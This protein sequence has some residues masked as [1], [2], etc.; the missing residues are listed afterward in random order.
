MSYRTPSATTWSRRRFLPTLAT[1]LAISVT[2]LMSREASAAEQIQPLNR[3]PRMVHEYFVKQVRQSQQGNRLAN[4]SVKTKGDAQ[5]YIDEVR[6]KIRECFGPDPQRTPLNAHVTGVIE[7]EAYRIEKLIF[8]SRPNF[9]VTANVYVPNGIDR[10]VPGVVGTC[11]HTP[12]GKAAESYQA[13]AQ[14]LAKQGY[15][16]I[17]YDPIGQGERSQYVNDQL[18]SQI[19]LGTS[20]HLHAGNQ[21]FLVGEFFGAWRA[22]DGVRALD[23]LLSREDVDPGHVGVTGNSGGGT[24]TTWLAG[25]EPRWTMV[26]PSCFVTT[27]L[28][29]M[30]NE[31]PADTE[32]CPPKALALGLD[33]ADFLVASAPD[34]TIVLAKERDFFDVRGSVEAFGRLRHLYRLLEEESQVSLFTGPTDHGFSQENREAMYGWFNRATRPSDANREPVASVAP[35]IHVAPESHV[36]PEIHVEPEIHIEPEASLWCTPHG[37]VA[38]RQPN[39]V[40]SFTRDTARLLDKERGVVRG[41]ALKQ[42]VAEVLKLR[43]RPSQ[44]PEFR[45]LR[46]TRSRDYP[47]PFHIH[48]AVE[49]ENDI[50]TIVTMLGQQRMQ[51][52]PPRIGKR[53]TLYVSHRSSDAELRDEPLIAKLIADEPDFPFFA[54][55]VRGTGDSQPN[56]CGGRDFDSQYGADY[57]YAIHSL[58]LDRPYLGQKTT[59]VLRVLDWLES[60][61]YTDIHLVGKGRGALPTTFAALMDDRVK[62][63]TLKNAMTSYS[64]VAQSER[65][66][67]PLS[68]LLPSVLSHFDLPDCYRELESKALKSIEPWDANENATS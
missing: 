10:P 37:H 45:I 6:G 20:Q 12:N 22:W 35:E 24:M 64:D 13:F 62:K 1:P 65:Y 16:C 5:V 55:D 31:L 14:G 9:P 30:E 56:T 28:H 60:Y 3:F 41:E 21:Q 67:W 54:C 2:G 53:A 11:G 66:E 19:A 26:A 15:I 57:F 17:V 34:A 27:F 33:H 68:S 48:Y 47:Q 39:T 44:A 46:D 8:D 4:G 36:A 25:I 40:F 49:T 18:K 42:A 59:D 7:R 58:M 32:Q 43:S 50:L 29:N 51:S 63:V 23:Y 52:R 61:G 38:E